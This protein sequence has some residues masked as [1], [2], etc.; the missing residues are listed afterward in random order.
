MNGDIRCL[1]PGNRAKVEGVLSEKVRRWAQSWFA[2]DA[3]ISIVFQDKL[4]PETQTIKGEGIY[5]IKEGV[6]YLQ[7]YNMSVRDVVAHLLSD[8]A[9]YFLTDN[10]REL[11]NKV[12]EECQQSLL[13]YLVGEN[14]LKS[15]ETK[16][17]FHHVLFMDICL[18]PFHARLKLDKQWLREAGYLEGVKKRMP[19]A[20]RMSAIEGQ[21][22]ALSA[23]LCSG[24]IT[25]DELL[26]LSAGNVLKLDH[27]L[28][29]PIQLKV[30]GQG[31]PV[32]SYLIKQ[33]N[34]KALLFAE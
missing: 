23:E 16:D 9:E 3:E 27:K 31:I 30:T 21:R 2:A 24:T 11:M 12:Y 26:K 20:S 5:R 1:G 7:P 29:Q 8:S 22:V 10:D 18:G 19:S 13:Q 34:R 4:F 25:L 6:C 33:K 17:D 15:T 28:D 14:E 32:K